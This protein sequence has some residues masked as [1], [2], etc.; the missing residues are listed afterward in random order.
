MKVISKLKIIRSNQLVEW[1]TAVVY[2]NHTSSHMNHKPLY[3][4]TFAKFMAVSKFYDHVPVEYCRLNWQIFRF[5][6]QA[7]SGLWPHVCLVSWNCFCL[8]YRYVCVCMHVSAL[9]AINYI[10]V[11]LN[12]YNQFVTFRNLTKHFLCMGAAIVTKY[13]VTETNLIRLC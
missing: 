4:W 12:L 2:V 8:W 1:D 10:H 7:C 13:I 6:N 9:E 11:I 5:L 3:K